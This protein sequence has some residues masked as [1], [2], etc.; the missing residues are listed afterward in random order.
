[1]ISPDMLARI[2][3]PRTA[4]SAETMTNWLPI[5]LGPM[6][7]RPGTEYLHA[8]YGNKKA[9]HIPFVY[10]YD[11]VA[12][13]EL[14]DYALKVYNDLLDNVVTRPAVS[15]AVANGGFDTDVASWT[16]ADE[17]GTAASVWL[18]GGYLSLTGDGTNAAKRTQQVT[19]A[20]GDQNVLHALNIHI[21]RGPV[22][23]RVGSTSG[24]GEYISETRLATGYHSLAFTPTGNF[25]ITLLAR[26]KYPALVD[27]IQVAGTG[28]M[29]LTTPWPEAYLPNIRFEQSADV[30]WVTCNGV[31]TKQIERR[32]TQSWSIVDYEADKGPFRAE[33]ATTTTITPSALTGLVTLTASTPTFQSTHVD[34]IWQIRS[35][36]Q[37]VTSSLSASN[38]WTNTILVQTAG[39]ARMF[40]L[41]ISGTWSGTVTLQRDI[42]G[43]GSWEDVESF[44]TNQSTTLN[45][46][47]D[48][49]VIYYRLGFKAGAYTS[50]TAVCSLSYASGTLTGR[51]R[52]TAVASSTS[53]TAYVMEDFGALTASTKWSEGAWSDYRGH[54]SALTL[55][56]GRLWLG[57]LDK[58]WASVSD[59]YPNHDADTVGDSGPIARTV[60]SGSVPT[61]RWMK[62][63]ESIFAGGDLAEF[64]VRSSAEEAL[65][66]P[67]NTAARKLT[68]YGSYNV[69][70]INVDQTIVYVDRTFRRLRELLPDSSSA[71]GGY[72]ANDMTMVAPEVAGPTILD[73]FETMAAQKSPWVTFYAQRTDGKVAVLV[74]SPQEEVRAWCVYDF[75]GG[76]VEEVFMVPGPYYDR[77][78]LTIKRTINSSTVRYVERL[79]RPDQARGGDGNRCTDSSVVYSGS[80]TTTITGL[81]HLEG[82][83]VAV[84][85]DQTDMGTFTVAG[86]QIT[87]TTAASEVTA[88]LAYTAQ[89]KSAKLVQDLRAVGELSNRGRITQLGVIL[90]QTHARGLQYGPDFTYLD[91]LPVVEDGVKVDI[92]G[93]WSAYNGDFMPFNGT[94]DTDSRLCLQAQSPRPCTVAAAVIKFD[95]S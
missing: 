15:S 82:E 48:N 4:L 21:S 79:Y 60:G 88:G 85:G 2:D 5:P 37:Y 91:D 84:W 38:S 52:I 14:T 70:A 26:N 89:F 50:G 40:G 59:D 65:L 94:Y 12:G 49:Q 20:G 10:A 95:R 29:I 44:T 31:R 1:M 74:S 41:T 76:D 22:Y 24:G 32:G 66:T 71:T 19:V 73:G 93:L 64:R 30:I 18:T 86:G 69:D 35:N 57:G 25:H 80:A 45:D 78:F 68:T 17:G 13:I 72:I 61:L 34:S 3:V 43:L 23:L 36:G 47:L 87:L 16:D 54:P 58:F 39:T 67:T 75:P 7:L 56:D 81:A 27:S 92:D 11:D 90:T 83:E 77:I 46:L 42:G 62:S 51:A 33:N 28:D 6:M 53:A 9:K 55:H 63:A 8:T